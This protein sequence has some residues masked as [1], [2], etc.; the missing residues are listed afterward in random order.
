[1]YRVLFGYAPLSTLMLQQRCILNIIFYHISIHWYRV[2]FDYALLGNINMSIIQH[3]ISEK[4]NVWLISTSSCS[5]VPLWSNTDAFCLRTIFYYIYIYMYL[6]TCIEYFLGML[7]WVPS[8]SNTC[9]FGHCILSHINSL[10][11][12][13]FWVRS[14]GQY[15]YKYYIAFYIWTVLKIQMSD[16]FPLRLPHTWI[17]TQMHFAPL[18]KEYFLTMLPRLCLCSRMLASVQVL[19][20]LQGGEAGNLSIHLSIRSSDDDSGGILKQAGAECHRYLVSANSA[21]HDS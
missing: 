4:S 12:S 3:I 10:V 5:R 8:W 17:T 20:T 7:L 6:F 15:K 13:N 11:L 14:S 19:T 9:F 21:R 18:H 1:M 16:W 2:L